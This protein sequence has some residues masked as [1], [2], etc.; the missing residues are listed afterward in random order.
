MKME[1][2]VM[3]KIYGSTSDSVILTPEKCNQI[4]QSLT[5]LIW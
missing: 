1:A 5:E 4:F 3:V 2:S